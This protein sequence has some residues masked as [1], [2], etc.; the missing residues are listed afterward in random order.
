[1]SALTLSS[2][3]PCASCSF[4]SLFN[5]DLIIAHALKP[6]HRKYLETGENDGVLVTYPLLAT[7]DRF[8]KQAGATSKKEWYGA[9]FLPWKELSSNL[10][11]AEQ[12]LASADHADT[13]T[14]AALVAK[15]DACAYLLDASSAFVSPGSSVD[16]RGLPV[17]NK[18][19]PQAGNGK[20]VFNPFEAQRQRKPGS[21]LHRGA[22]SWTVSASACGYTGALAVTE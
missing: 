19:R 3:L 16:I 22:K 20:H 13:A 8:G 4:S 11:A 17:R 14:R 18:G 6:E 9:R 21:E 12:A 10:K 5:Q 1:M 15:R 7:T 2:P